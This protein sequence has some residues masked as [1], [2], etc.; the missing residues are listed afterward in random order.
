MGDAVDEPSAAQRSNLPSAAFYPASFFA[1]EDGDYDEEGQFRVSLSKLPHHIND[2]EDPFGN[3][4][5]DIPRLRNALARF[6]QV[7]WDGFPDGTKE[8]TRA[9]LERH[10]D[11][12][13]AS[14][15]KE[16]STCR[17][18]E[19]NSLSLDIVDF[20]SGKF[21]DIRNRLNA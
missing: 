1:G 6:N 11:G 2:V 9:H 7:D 12:I 16:C 14:R 4:S 10:A 21:I 15:T 20:R 18:M 5:V 19:I 13:L 17:E 3:E 8:K